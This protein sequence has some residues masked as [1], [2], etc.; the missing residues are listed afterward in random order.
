MTP[1]KHQLTNEEKENN[2]HRKSAK[3]RKIENEKSHTD[4]EIFFFGKFK[5]IALISMKIVQK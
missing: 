1:S 2:C 4:Y 5:I 3:N